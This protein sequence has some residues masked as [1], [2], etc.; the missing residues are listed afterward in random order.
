M[1]KLLVL[2]VLVAPMSAQADTA[3]PTSRQ[4]NKHFSECARLSTEAYDIIRDRHR[5]V[6]PTAEGLLKHRLSKHSGVFGL[7]NWRIEEAVLHAY[8]QPQISSGIFEIERAAEKYAGETLV[9]CL[10][11]GKHPVALDFIRTDYRP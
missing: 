9:S 3:H 10:R 5:Y 7:S 1:R 2:A 11:T 4:I 6:S 8:S